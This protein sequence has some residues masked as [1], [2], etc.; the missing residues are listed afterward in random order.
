MKLIKA[1]PIFFIVGLAGCNASQFE[2]AQPESESVITQADLRLTAMDRQ[3]YLA[4]YEGETDI[5]LGE[6]AELALVEEFRKPSKS[7]DLI[8]LPPGFEDS[9]SVHG[10]ETETRSVAVIGRDGDIVLVLDS[11]Y[12]KDEEFAQK[13]V[14][15]YEY[16]FGPPVDRILND[17]TH[18]LF[19]RDGDVRL[20]VM[21]DKDSYGKHTLAI[22]LGQ[23]KTMTT[24]RM[25]KEAAQNDAAK[26]EKLR[27][28]QESS[29]SATN[30]DN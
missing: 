15:R 16:R 28:S 14:D 6:K 23:S 12:G 7:I 21:D 18:Y 9:F 30:E 11:Y 13:L 2:L 20:M 29:K 4:V 27:K 26:A 5:R 8:E 10:W 24:L 25:T 3:S 22:G 19:W 1:V 17:N